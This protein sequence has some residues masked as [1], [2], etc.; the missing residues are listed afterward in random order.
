MKMEEERENL[1]KK[2]SL[3][4]HQILLYRLM[5]S[6][7]IK[8]KTFVEQNQSIN[9]MSLNHRIMSLNPRICMVCVA[10]QAIQPP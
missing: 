6:K 9:F 4:A 10:I 2:N 3:R 7:A 8:T 5:K 1:D